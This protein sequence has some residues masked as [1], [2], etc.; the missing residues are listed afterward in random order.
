MDRVNDWSE[1]VPFISQ[2]VF[3]TDRNLWVY[4]TLKDTFRLQLTQTIAED[5][6]RQAL[7]Y[8]S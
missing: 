8:R 5:T 3:D 1:R 2:L 4:D 6:I 7:N